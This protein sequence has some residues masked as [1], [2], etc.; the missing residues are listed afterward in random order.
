MTKADLL[1][2]YEQ[3]KGMLS[4]EVRSLAEKVLGEIPDDYVSVEMDTWGD[5]F[6]AEGYAPGGRI[7][8][9]EAIDSVNEN[10]GPLLSFAIEKNTWGQEQPIECGVHLTVGQW[11]KVRNFADK[12]FGLDAHTPKQDGPI[13]LARAGALKVGTIDSQQAV[14]LDFPGVG[15]CV[16]PAEEAVEL[17]KGVTI[18]IAHLAGMTDAAE[19][20]DAIGNAGSTDNVA[21]LLKSRGIN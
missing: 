10:T 14:M 8:L 5:G 9:M 7:T 15:Y 12:V 16:F 11:L 17:I 21:A 13:D 2:E 6:G 1:A 3:I 4:P 18:A 20:V 19:F